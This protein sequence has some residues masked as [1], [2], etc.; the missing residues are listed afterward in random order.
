MRAGKP[1]R[2]EVRSAMLPGM[3][4]KARV[5]I[6]G[7]GN[8]GS[9]LAR[10][11]QLAGYA[12][13]AVI[14]RPRGGSLTKARRLAKQVGAR[15]AIDMSSM[16]AELVWFCVPDSA[17]AAAAESVA[18]QVEWK[19]RVALHSSGALGSDELVSLR[20]RGAAVASVHPLMTFV[21]GSRPV[22]RG[23]PF[24][25]EGDAEAIGVARRVVLD[26][27]GLAYTIRK[28][29]KAAYHA[30]GTFA[31]PLLTA[32]LATTEEVASLAGVSR[33]AARQR[34]IPI[35]LQTLANYA[36]LGAAGGFSGPIVRG[37]VDTIRSHIR[38]LRNMPVAREVYL[39]LAKAALTYL[40][41]KAKR[42]L[43]EELKSA[44]RKRRRK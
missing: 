16:R 2:P 21:R 13:E 11:L 41:G 29:D 33:K 31:S 8:L 32:L 27:G 40:P 25:L 44:P 1:P 3:A 5:A 14:S 43:M 37:D 20:R 4:E 15:T 6:V 30:W 10:S 7:A 28:E 19:G 42:D 39:S 17:I 34:M 22:L 23:V 9:A 35:L 26:L 24:A 12:I 18:K 38:T 36:S